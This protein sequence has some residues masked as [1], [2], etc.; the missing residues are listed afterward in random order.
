MI[1]RDRLADYSEGGP[2]AKYVFNGLTAGQIENA[3]AGFFA[4]RGYKL[5]SG[6]PDNG[7]YGAGSEIARLLLGG[8][9]KRY[10]FKILIQA[11]GEMTELVIRKGMSGFWGGLLG[12]SAMNREFKAVKAEILSWPIAE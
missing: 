11:G 1:L 7:V 8:F 10:K 2:A 4:T 6:G 9:V 3:V 5:E 12:Y